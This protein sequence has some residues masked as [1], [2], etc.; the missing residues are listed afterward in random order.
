M[1]KRSKSFYGRIEEYKGLNLLLD[2]M[3][4]PEMQHIRLLSV[5]RGSDD[6]QIR[7]IVNSL[8]NV[9]FINDYVPDKELAKYIKQSR[10]VILPYKS[11][12]GSQTITI[13]NYY[14]KMVLAT[15][16]G[17]F[18]EYIQEGKNGFFIDSYTKEDIKKAMLKMA[19]IDESTYKERIKNEYDKYDIKCIAEKVYRVVSDA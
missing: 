6:Q 19:C 16:V 13:A 7:K 12:T 9:K 11:A 8:V 4:D 1:E 10:F 18:P 3:K 15:K 17:C 5:G 2:A 14:E